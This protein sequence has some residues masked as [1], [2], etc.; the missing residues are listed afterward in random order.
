MLSVCGIDCSACTIHLRTREELDYWRSQKVDTDKVRC[1]GCRSERKEGLHWSPD[2]GI[3]ACCLNRKGL[4]F[5]A[6]CD[7]LDE[8]GLIRDF[9]ADLEHHRQAVM[10]LRKMKRVG[11]ER[12]LAENGYA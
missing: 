9:V 1:A 5:C 6:Q 4:E 10:R 12:W 7:E 3:V 11:V 8:C 2:C